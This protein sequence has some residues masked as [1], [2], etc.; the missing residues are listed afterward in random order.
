MTPDVTHYNPDPEYLRGLLA[1]ANLTQNGAAKTIG[2]SA[3]MLRSYVCLNPND[4][5]KCP[6]PVQFALE[7]LALEFRHD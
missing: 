3:R 1:K 4:Y 6:Y 7:C 5:R 2:V